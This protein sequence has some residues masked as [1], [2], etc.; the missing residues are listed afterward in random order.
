MYQTE[1]PL[2]SILSFGEEGA[3]GS[4]YIVTENLP[5]SSYSLVIDANRNGDLTGD[6]VYTAN[7]CVTIQPPPELILDYPTGPLRQRNCTLAIFCTG[8]VEGT[9]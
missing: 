4:F 7:S 5:K 2:Y 6:L 9:Q 1:H 3:L 8:F